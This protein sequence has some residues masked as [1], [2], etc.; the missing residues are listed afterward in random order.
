MT[1]AVDL[2][3]D[4]AIWQVKD[5][6]KTQDYMTCP[7]KYFFRHVLG[8]SNEISADTGVKNIHLEFGTAWHLAMEV[9]LDQGYTAEA[10]MNAFD[11][12]MEYYREAFPA[13]MDEFHKPKT[14][15]NVLRALPQYCAKYRQDDFELL[16]M[17]TAGSVPIDDDRLVY[18][19]CDAICRGPNGIFS[20]EHKTGSR[21]G[22]SWGAQWRQKMQMG[23]YSHVLYCMYPESEVYGIVVNGAFFANAPVMKRDGTPRAGSR[24][25]EFHRVPVR[26][27]LEHM[28]AWHKEI[29]F[30]FDSIDRDHQMLAETDDGDAVMCAFPKNTE[31]CT[32]YGIC[33]YMD[34]CSIWTNPVQHIEIVP[35]GLTEE[36]WD[37]RN[38]PTVKETLNL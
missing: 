10:C 32:K 5:A 17:E 13:E 9:L 3:P 38:I 25:N 35:V 28:D 23:V 1:K 15:E 8:W 14:P 29:S 27:T 7:R 16:H 4:H 11:V 36:F 33:P 21:F 22:T 12:F 31:S 24:D 2:I 18:F 19:K 6:S 20:L 37:P 30:W 26:K 34:Q